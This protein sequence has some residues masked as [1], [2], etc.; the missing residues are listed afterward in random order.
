MV[1]A[2]HANLPLTDWTGEWAKDDQIVPKDRWFR[3]RTIALFTI[4]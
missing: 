3:N 1:R 4:W 2:V